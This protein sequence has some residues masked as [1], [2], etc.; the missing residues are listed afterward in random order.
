M[1]YFLIEISKLSTKETFEKG[2]YEYNTPNEAIAQFHKK[3][4]GAMSNDTYE[5]ELVM[6]INEIG[7][8]L[9]TEHYEKE[10]SED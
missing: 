5:K 4:G 2:I 10:A 3:L 6:V 9:K 8:V 7:G 1:K